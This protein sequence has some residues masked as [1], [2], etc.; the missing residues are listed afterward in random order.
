MAGDMKVFKAQFVE[1]PLYGIVMR[2]LEE[3][4]KKEK[5][6]Y[7]AGSP[8]EADRTYRF[9]YVKALGEVRREIQT[10]IAN[11]GRE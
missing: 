10:I 5:D 4:E 2:R 3:K 11:I 7:F 9:C 8:D 1:N 6:N